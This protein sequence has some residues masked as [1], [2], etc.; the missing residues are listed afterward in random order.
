MN[1]YTSNQ[2][3]NN[4]SNTI[5]VQDALNKIKPYNSINSNS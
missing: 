2:S 4:K 3:L 5:N 1:E